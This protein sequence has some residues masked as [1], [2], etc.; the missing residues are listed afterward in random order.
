VIAKEQALDLAED[1][2]SAM[3]KS[4][5]RDLLADSEPYVELPRVTELR[6]RLRLA[7]GE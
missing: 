6:D 3:V 7:L 2:P 4:R 5:L 1:S